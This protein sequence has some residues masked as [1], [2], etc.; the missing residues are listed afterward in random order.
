ML[1]GMVIEHYS[2]DRALVAV[3]IGIRVNG[4]RS[5]L[6]RRPSACIA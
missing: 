4:I 3:K 5:V 1:S 6:A 2:D